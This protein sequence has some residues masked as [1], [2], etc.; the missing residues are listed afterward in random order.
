MILSESA[1]KHAFLTISDNFFQFHQKREKSFSHVFSRIWPKF[2]W[3]SMKNAFLKI[4]KDFSQNLN[5]HKNMLFSRFLM[6]F[7]QFYQKRQKGIFSRFPQNWPDFLNQHVNMLFSRFLMIFSLFHQK[8]KKSFSLDFKQNRPDF[9]WISI[10]KCFSHDFWWFFPSFIK[11]VK[12]HFLWS[13]SRIDMILSE[14]ARKHAFL[15][16][17]D[18]FF[19]FHQKKANGLFLTF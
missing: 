8:G 19:Q 2:I 9:V 10:K 12:S 11:K 18:D 3:I 7:A 13:S 6:I 15:L 4:S 16:I 14:S 1:R 17:S 5:Q